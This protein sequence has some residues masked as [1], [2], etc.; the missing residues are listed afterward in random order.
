MWQSDAKERPTRIKNS[1]QKPALKER[2]LEPDS[3]SR[4]PRLI[5]ICEQTANLTKQALLVD[6][7]K[8]IDE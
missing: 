6:E 8:Q 3:S 4:D 1:I 7:S 2:L 5:W